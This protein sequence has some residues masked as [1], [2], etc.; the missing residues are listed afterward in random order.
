MLPPIWYWTIQIPPERPEFG[1]RLEQRCLRFFRVHLGP[2]WRRL[3]PSC[4]AVARVLCSLQ[5]LHTLLCI[6]PRFELLNTKSFSLRFCPSRYKIKKTGWGSEHSPWTGPRQSK[7]CGSWPIAH[8]PPPITWPLLGDWPIWASLGN[9]FLSLV[10]YW[11][12][13]PNKVSYSY[14]RCWAV[15]ISPVYISGWSLYLYFIQKYLKN[16]VWNV[17]NVGRAV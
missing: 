10:G 16:S 13:T 6:F 8:P 15:C 3:A 9:Q 1:W 17:L 4:W 11:V 7:C 14:K 12:K 5:C 2:H